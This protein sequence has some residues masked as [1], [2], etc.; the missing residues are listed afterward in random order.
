M[1]QIQRRFRLLAF[2]AVCIVAGANA[3][4]IAV[5]SFELLPMDLTANTYGTIEIDQNGE[6]AAL[7]KM[8]TTQTGFV[9]DGGMMGIVKTRQETAELW[10]Y[11]PHGIRRIVIKHQQ[12]GQ[13]EY[14][15]PIPIEKARTYKMVL[16]DDLA[17][18]RQP[19]QTT[20]ADS[21]P[22]ASTRQNVM[23]DASQPVDA[24]VLPPSV[25][26]GHFSFG[27][28]YTRASVFGDS[29]SSVTQPSSFYLQAGYDLPLIGPLSLRSGLRFTSTSGSSAETDRFFSS[30]TP[31]PS[32]S[33]I[34]WKESFLHIPLELA[35]NL[36]VGE[37]ISFGLFAGAAPGYG[38]SSTASNP[39]N[40]TSFS[41]Y[42]TQNYGHFDILFCG[43]V[44]FDVV[45]T[46]RLTAGYNFSPYYRHLDRLEHVRHTYL[47]VGLSVLF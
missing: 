4:H 12:L 25:R 32:G 45:R 20:Q 19:Q 34:R 35:L 41:L 11:V 23:P 9:I 31:S 13:L 39:E 21:L 8:V 15:F 24:P 26:R 10:I 17:A 43:G 44:T 40:K 5:E 42:G 6:V 16:N 37:A 33:H 7:I 46:V 2:L 18:I 1:R 3:Q 38:L 28:G 30:I 22:T 27:G 36:P 14:Y 47:H 29:G